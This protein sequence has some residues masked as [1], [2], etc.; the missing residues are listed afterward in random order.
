M[1][2]AVAAPTTP[3]GIYEIR[4]TGLA[5]RADQDFADDLFRAVET[6]LD[7][8]P[9][10]QINKIDCPKPVDKPN[11]W[12]MILR[13]GG[14]PFLNFDHIEIDGDVW[15]PE[16]CTQAG[17]KIP[18]VM[19]ADHYASGKTVNRIWF[20]HYVSDT[21]FPVVVVMTADGFFNVGGAGKPMLQ[22]AANRMGFIGAPFTNG[23]RP[24]VCL[25]IDTW[26][27]FRYYN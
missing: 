12:A 25:G 5:V 8:E 6:D 2:T 1:E 21:S 17:S 23:W 19:I 20:T 10:D 9:F 11:G 4:K 16:P 24:M 7:K 3:D 26:V 22:G 14:R 15:S 13:T 18:P 27:E